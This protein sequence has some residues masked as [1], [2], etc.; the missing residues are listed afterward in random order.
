MHLTRLRSTAV[1]RLCPLLTSAISALEASGA[2]S[3]LAA[4][5]SAVSVSRAGGL[6]A[7]LISCGAATLLCAE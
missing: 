4:A 7:K 6:L 1:G 5:T 2:V 3:P